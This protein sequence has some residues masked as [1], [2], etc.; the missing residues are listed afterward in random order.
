M[1]QRVLRI[2]LVVLLAGGIG[3]VWWFRD[4]VTPATVAA[5]VEGL[6]VW[7]PLVF[8]GSLT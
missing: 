2:S 3:L 8:V 7:G 1:S 5:W 6:G 4:T